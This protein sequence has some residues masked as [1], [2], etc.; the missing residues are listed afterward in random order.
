MADVYTNIVEQSIL[1][2]TTDSG[3]KVDVAVTGE[4]HLEAAI[5]APRLPFGSVHVENLTPVFQSDAV[6]AI[7]AN[8]Q[9]TFASG[10]GAATVSNSAFNIQTGTTIYSQASIQSRKRLRY[11]PGQGVV[12]R[13]T[14]KY[15]T[16]VTSS[17]QVVGFGHAEDGV[18]VGYKNTDFGILYSVRGKREVR[19][20]TISTKS[21]HA[22]NAV[23]TLNGTAFNVPVTNGAST[24]VTAN[25]IAAYASYTGWKAES[26][27]STV[28]FVKDAVGVISGSFS[29]TGTSVIGSFA[30]SSA[31]QA[32]TETFITQANWNGD[33]L[34]GTGPSGF[35]IDPT[36]LNVFQIKIQYLGAGAITFE[37]EIP[38]AGNNPDWVV[39]HSI[40][41]PNTLTA[42]SFGNPSFPFTMAVYSAGSTTNLTLECGSYAG[43]IEG[44]KMLHGARLSYV[45]SLTNVGATNYQALFSIKNTRYF[46]GRANQSVINLLSASGALKHTSP[47]IFYL[48]KNGTL[49]GAPNWASYSTDSCT[50]FDNTATTVT[51]S[52]NSQLV[53]TAHLGDTGEFDHHFNSGSEE[54]EVQPGEWITLAAKAVTGTPSYV[55][56]SL[57]T[58]EDK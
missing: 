27:G 46:K 48:I 41:L 34:D 28:V 2:G 47:C 56:G 1:K 36:K 55:T 58:R 42:T 14:A 21:S 32:A 50:L 33:K 16:P 18:Y 20:L 49:G 23:V 12:G 38:Y 17:Y 10:S 19:T 31:G 54:L 8:Q 4:G 15:T 43:F 25:E 52:D 3:E 13:F 44:E 53:W 29:I 57:N 35:T 51:F 6:Y 37:A 30:Q 11:R 7:L 45:N 26:V 24:I 22:E 40:N 5:H 39:V 9:T